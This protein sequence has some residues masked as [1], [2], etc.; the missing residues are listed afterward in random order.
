MLFR[1]AGGLFVLALGLS[2]ANV[3][4]TPSD[5]IGVCGI[6]AGLALLTGL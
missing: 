2:E 5:L 1:I 4:Q 6:I 3:F